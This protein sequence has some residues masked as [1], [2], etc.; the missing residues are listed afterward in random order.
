M[1]KV[2][3]YSQSDVAKMVRELTYFLQCV[4]FPESIQKMKE[5]LAGQCENELMRE[6]DELKDKV[7]K[8]QDEL[9]ELLSAEVERRKAE[10]QKEKELEEAKERNKA[11]FEDS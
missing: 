1:I 11:S 6:R 8:L 10:I 7:S 3:F 2:F 9:L 5:E 4:D